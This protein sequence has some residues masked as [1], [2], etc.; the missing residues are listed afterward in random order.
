MCKKKHYNIIKCILFILLLGAS[1]T[2]LLNFKIVLVNGDSMQPTYSNNQILLAKKNTTIKSND[3]IVFHVDNS[4]ILRELLEYPV[5]QFHFVM[6]AFMLTIRNLNPI[7]TTE[8]M[9]L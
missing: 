5:I 9:K 3:V 4:L 7:P 2:F 8:L 6:V 1:L